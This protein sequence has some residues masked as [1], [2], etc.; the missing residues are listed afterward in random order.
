MIK[1][2]S[3]LSRSDYYGHLISES[4]VCPLVK[5]FI[6]CTFLSFRKY[7]NSFN[8]YSILPRNPQKTSEGIV[9]KGGKEKRD[10]GKGRRKCLT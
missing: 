1:V 5:P 4:F 6:L 9:G 3:T 2:F 7:I 8:E 10:E